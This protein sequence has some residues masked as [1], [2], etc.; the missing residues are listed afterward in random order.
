MKRIIWVSLL[1]ALAGVLLPLIF[2]S[3]NRSDY[4]GD[5]T[6]DSPQVSPD[7]SPEVSTT[8]ALYT[9]DEELVFTVKV[10]DQQLEMNMADY[11]PCAIAAEMP[12][13]F[14]VEAL[15]AQAVAART[16]VI[17]CTQHE[18]PKHPDAD[19][20]TDSGCCLAYLDE[21][22]LRGN[23]GEA[24]DANF[25]IATAAAAD[26]NGLIISYDDLPILATFHS[27]SAGMT[28]KGGELWGDVPYLATV[29]S[30]ETADDVPNFVTTVDVSSANFKESILLL[31]PDVVFGEDANA[32][33]SSIEN[34]DSGRV[35]SVVICGTTVTGS[36]MR[37][38]FSLRSTA[39]TLEFN[40]TSFLFTVTGYGH[41]L[42]LSQY[43]ANV[44]AKK[45]FDYKEILQHYYPNTTLGA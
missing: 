18:N 30:P 22:A 16:Y 25:A 37:K 5:E 6:L 13:S 44:M 4:K 8:P 31:F 14:E 40:G 33:V 43:G 19:I 15:R 28:E 45:G 32:W 21:T 7:P 26:T 2:L 12:V 36:Q 23:W 42:G 34:D 35:R 27:S 9:S 11:L 24:F 41:G 3:G 38:L 17:Y 39:F 1:L 10:G 29:E 20:C